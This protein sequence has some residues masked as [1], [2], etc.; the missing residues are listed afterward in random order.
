MKMGAPAWLL[1]R[2][3]QPRSWRRSGWPWSSAAPQAV[4]V[5]RLS[6]R[7]GLLCDS[8]DR[9]DGIERSL[10]AQRWSRLGVP[11]WKRIVCGVYNSCADR[12]HPVHNAA[13]RCFVCDYGPVSLSCLLHPEPPT[14]RWAGPRLVSQIT[15]WNS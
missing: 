4:A 15:L 14:T 5:N 2:L 6:C 1:L 9:S 3:C 10:H 7:F 13:P 8:C 12:H 11:C